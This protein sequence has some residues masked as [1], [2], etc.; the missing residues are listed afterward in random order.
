V[1]NIDHLNDMLDLIV[2]RE[3]SSLYLNVP[4]N[5]LVVVH[6]RRINH[7]EYHLFNLSVV[8]FKNVFGSKLFHFFMILISFNVTSIV[9]VLRSIERS[10]GLKDFEFI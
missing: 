6:R 4:W 1:R 10:I 2:P 5:M 8:Q 9:K 7:D 3:S